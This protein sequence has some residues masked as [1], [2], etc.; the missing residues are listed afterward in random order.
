LFLTLDSSDAEFADQVKKGLNGPQV[1]KLGQTNE[2]L[3]NGEIDALE[4]DGPKPLVARKLVLEGNAEADTGGYS[5]PDRLPGIQLH[6]YPRHDFEFAESIFE[7]SP[8]H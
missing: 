8:G 7:N 1:F 6:D 5:L 2:I 3:A 4:R